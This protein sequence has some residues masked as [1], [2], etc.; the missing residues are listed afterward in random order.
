MIHDMVHFI[1]KLDHYSAKMNGKKLFPGVT[2]SLA[3]SRRRRWQDY[4]GLPVFFHQ[5]PV[6]EVEEAAGDSAVSR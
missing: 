3:G 1:P 5:H 6:L 4:G 2:S